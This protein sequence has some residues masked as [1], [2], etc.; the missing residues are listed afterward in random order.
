MPFVL[1]NYSSLYPI[2]A[3]VN[4]L[5]VLDLRKYDYRMEWEILN[6]I[7]PRYGTR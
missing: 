3:N 6:K 7:F 5:F 1:Q 4:D 2:S